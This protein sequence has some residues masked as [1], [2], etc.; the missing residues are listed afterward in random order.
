VP[1]GSRE[2]DH[3]P[4]YA[5]RSKAYNH[6]YPFWDIDTVSQLVTALWVLEKLARR[7]T[8][9]ELLVEEM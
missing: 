2:N 1:H 7:W 9:I 3:N 8:E 4:V 6:L 5:I